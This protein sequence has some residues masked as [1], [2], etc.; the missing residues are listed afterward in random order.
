VT[1]QNKKHEKITIIQIFGILG[2]K[3][4]LHGFGDVMMETRLLP[5]K[6]CFWL[7]PQMRFKFQVPPCGRARFAP[8][9][10]HQRAS[11]Q[12][13]LVLSSWLHH[14][15]IIPS[16]AHLA[17]VPPPTP[18]ALPGPL[19]VQACKSMYRTHFFNLNPKA[20]WVD[21][22]LQADLCEVLYLQTFNSIHSHTRPI[23][24]Q[25]G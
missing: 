15:T 13:R 23:E 5:P 4:N 11:H 16:T 12:G 2:G 6:R 7:T 1:D 3:K 10:L 24:V 9:Q 8:S 17:Q 22:L 14:C 20:S 19:D 21:I 18:R 25:T